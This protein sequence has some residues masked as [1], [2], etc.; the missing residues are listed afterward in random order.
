MVLENLPKNANPHR[1]KLR[2]AIIG[3][4]F[5]ASK[6][7]W[8]AYTARTHDEEDV[9]IIAV[10][11]VCEARL[12]QA[13]S[14]MMYCVRT[15]NNYR[16]LIDKEHFNL[17]FVDIATPPAYHAEVAHYA[18]TAG[19]H[20]LCEKPVTA[21]GQEIEQLLTL[22]QQKQRVLFPVHNYKH[23]PI[24]KAINEIIASGKIGTVH[25][26]TLQTFRN[27]HA[28]GVR[29]WRP[30]WR[31]EHTHSAGGIAMDHGSHSFYLT[32][33]WLGQYPTSVTAK[34]STLT[35][36]NFDTEDNFSSVLTFPNGVANLY[37]SWTAGVRKVIYTIQGSTGAIT[38]DDDNME[39]AVMKK[40]KS[41]GS[42]NNNSECNSASG[43]GGIKWEVERYSIA[44]K[45][46]DSSHT[47]WFN[48]LFS[49]FVKAIQNHDILNKE[50]LEAAL[51]VEIINR[52]YESAAN[53]STEMKI[54]QRNLA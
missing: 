4:G 51:C 5:I 50:I 8:P 39:I 22:A 25:A 53:N 31:R 48:S 10:A 46:M 45:W 11:D 6:G 32:F 40:E 20:V 30:H 13:Q 24:V 27:T 15:Y 49:Q 52:A 44:S 26:L 18:L 16:E 3:Y 12:Q 7:H 43:Y 38:V 41:A 54:N 37:L 33:A 34:M 28:V 9:E 42:S 19:L 14:D 29:E 35:P 36:G 1:R 21:T 2:G 47:S 23:A 17:D